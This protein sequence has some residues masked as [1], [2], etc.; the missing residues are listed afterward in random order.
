M[1]T[2]K[3]LEENT[4]PW[5]LLSEDM[6]EAFRGCKDLE[7]YDSSGVWIP[8]CTHMT[9]GAAVRKKPIPLT[10]PDIP[11]EFIKDEYKWAARDLNDEVFL[12]EHPPSCDRAAGIWHHDDHRCPQSPVQ[13]SNILDFDPGTC[14][15]KDSLVERPK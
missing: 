9:I 5:G 15:W 3:M 2:D 13:I 4:T 10:K 1:I 8:V 7:C 6:R 14:D 12:F 11:W